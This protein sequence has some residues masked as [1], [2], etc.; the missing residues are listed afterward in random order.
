MMNLANW[1]GASHSWY[2]IYKYSGEANDGALFYGNG[3][4]VG[5]DALGANQVPQNTS[6]IGT[7]TFR[8]FT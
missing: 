4:N 8:V 6:F 5:W 1:N 2:V 7:I 3:D